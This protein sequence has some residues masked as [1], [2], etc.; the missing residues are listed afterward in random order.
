MGMQ[1]AS[2]MW[3][4][5]DQEAIIE[6]LKSICNVMLHNE[7]GLVGVLPLRLRGRERCRLQLLPLTGRGSR[8]SADQRCDGT[9]EAEF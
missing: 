3:E 9:A 1:E 2:P 6:S 8:A 7:A 5:P 4:N